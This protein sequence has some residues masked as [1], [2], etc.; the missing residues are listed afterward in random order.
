[1]RP[2]RGPWAPLGTSVVLAGGI[3]AAE[4]AGTMNAEVARCAAISPADER[5]ACFDALA[6]AAIAGANERLA[7]YDELARSRLQLGS[8]GTPAVGSEPAAAAPAAAA[9]APP[10]SAATTAPATSAVATTA[11]ATSAGGSATQSFGLV[12][13]APPKREQGPKQ[14][15]ALVQKVEVDRYGNVR[16]SLDNGQAWDF[17]EADAIVRPGEAVTIRR[18]A[19]GSFLLTTGS[20]HTYRVTRRQ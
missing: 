8:G 13:R 7:C 19:L 2:R 6:C 5:L 11:A 1:M 17:A 3:A 15:A 4:T 14:I 9:G 12:R 18:A 10:P 16:V 20:H